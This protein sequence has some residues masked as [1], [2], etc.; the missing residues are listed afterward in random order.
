MKSNSNSIHGTD[1][2]RDCYRQRRLDSEFPEI[3]PFLKTGQHV[4]DVG[5]GPGS[6]TADVAQVVNPGHVVGVDS[7][8][9]SVEEASANAKKQGMSN[10]EFQLAD[11]YS[12]PFANKHFDLV[13]SHVV[14]DWLRNPVD[15]IKEQVRVAKSGGQVLMRVQEYGSAVFYPYFDSLEK[16][17]RAW[18]VLGDPNDSGFFWNSFVGRRSLE[19][20]E[21]AG[22]V[23]I[24]V[25]AVGATCSHASRDDLDRPGLP[26]ARFFDN[27]DANPYVRQ[28][29]ISAGAMSE[30]DFGKARDSFEAWKV[31]PH[32]LLLFVGVFAVGRVV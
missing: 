18:E 13:Y 1:A 21:K 5:C 7:E 2:L 20:F 30:D 12:L 8:S 3:Q 26:I 14:V 11:A 24:Q 10:L 28:K 22:L 4:L 32:A 27:I 25:H 6:I 17:V 15:A 9:R 29:L 31:H 16:F 19:I 23:D